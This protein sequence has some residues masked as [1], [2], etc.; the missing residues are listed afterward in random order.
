MSKPVPILME[1][2]P[3]AHDD[4]AGFGALQTPHG[5]LPLKAV[6][7]RARIDGLLTRTT[8]KQ[9]FVNPFDEHLEATYIFPLPDRAAVT[10]FRLTVAGRIVEG[11]L[12]ER[13]KARETYEKAIQAGHRAAI[14]EEERP[15]TF[16]MRVGNLPPRETAIVELT[17]TGPLPVDSGEATYRFPLVVAPRYIP[18]TPLPGE[19]VGG[20]TSPDTD[21]V[22]DASCITPPVLLPGQPNPVHLSLEVEVHRGGLS[23]SDFRSSLHALEEDGIRFR[24]GPNERMDRDFI[25]RFRVDESQIRTSLQYQPDA[26]FEGGTFALT[27]VPPRGGDT[28]R[29]PRDLVLVL[30]RSGSMQGWKMQAARRALARMVESLTADDRFAVLAFDNTIEQFPTDRTLQ[31]ATDRQRFQAVEFLSKVE[32]RGGT[33]IA[34]P[35]DQALSMLTDAQRDRILVLVTDG[36][37]GNEDQVLR[38]IAPRLAWIR[39][40]TLGVDQAV[41]EGFLKRLAGI[42]GGYMELVESPMRLDEVMDKVHRRIGSPVLSRLKL[43][44]AGLAFVP[45]SIV[46][47]RLPDLFP[48]MPLTIFGRYHGIRNSESGLSLQATDDA[49]RPWQAT[50]QGA[51]GEV[52]A[53]VWARGHIRDLEDRYAGTHGSAQLEARIVETSLKFGVLSRFTAFVAVDVKEV[54]NEKGQMHRVTQPV[55]LP[56]GWEMPPLRSDIDAMIGYVAAANSSAP[57]RRRAPRGTVD[58]MLAE[59]TDTAF[60]AARPR[61][62]K[63]LRGPTTLRP[64]CK[65]DAADRLQPSPAVDLT[66]YRGRAE[67][68]RKNLESS[69]DSLRALGILAI[70]LEELLDDLKSIGANDAER[71]PLVELLADLRAFIARSSPAAHDVTALTKQA[72]EVLEAFAKGKK[73]K[74]DH[75]RKFWK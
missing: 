17:L 55:E 71:Q 4:D 1:S 12:Q 7:V 5:N 8:V 60:E 49:G 16:T 21:A 52:L 73:L 27:I 40:F 11:Q 48:G 34:A 25:L 6:D 33:E 28:K 62:A 30:D 53:P 64:K 32:A 2:I 54:V 69:N 51:R 44:P 75:K 39:I 37:V 42:G 20:G 23:F 22:P 58:S 14:A 65:P 35:L 67:E 13:A 70:K 24:L 38:S 50:V 19:S 74:G 9:V 45:D 43:E 41:N 46:P 59:F 61:P 66:A 68:L 56:A 26:D 72:V 29:K 3:E 47:D 18:G 10:Q 15:N 63:S 31:S 36:Q 57:M